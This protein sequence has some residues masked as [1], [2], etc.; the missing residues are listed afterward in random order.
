[1][2]LVLQE[3]GLACG[4]ADRWVGD[5]LAE[6]PAMD[7]TAVVAHMLARGVLTEDQGVLGM[8]PVGERVFGRRHFIDVVAAFS[9]PM[10][11]AVRHGRAELGSVH[12]ASLARRDDAPIVIL[13]GGRRSRCQTPKA[14]SSTGSGSSR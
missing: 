2:A 1:M 5:A 14:T 6:V 4:D 13:L 3:G 9:S 10:L 8:G 12:P 7:R 11:L